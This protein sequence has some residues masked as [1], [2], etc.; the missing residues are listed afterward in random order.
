MILVPEVSPKSISGEKW[1]KTLAGFPAFV[2]YILLSSGHPSYWVTRAQ[3][4][5][6]AF[7]IQT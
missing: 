4:T 5:A 1:A 6:L 7:S 2:Y 3:H